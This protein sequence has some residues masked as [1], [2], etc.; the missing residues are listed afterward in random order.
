MLKI[1]RGCPITAILDVP[2]ERSIIQ[3][4]YHYPLF[5]GLHYFCALLL[6]LTKLEAQMLLQ[7]HYYIAVSLLNTRTLLLGRFW[8]FPSYLGFSISLPRQKGCSG[9]DEEFM[10][11]VKTINFSHEI[12][13]LTHTISHILELVF[14][15]E[16]LMYNLK[17]ENVL[18][19]VP[20]G[21]ISLR[22]LRSMKLPPWWS[23]ESL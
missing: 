9:K 10:A 8:S 11:S 5:L 3:I 16:L 22:S 1:C 7:I 23:S 19:C 13:N 6:F 4:C 21:M 15:S 17:M 14:T 2:I 20:S 12:S 18:R